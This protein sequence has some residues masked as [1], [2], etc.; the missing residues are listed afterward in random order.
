MFAA[1]DPG[2]DL[3]IERSASWAH[4]AGAPNGRSTEPASATAIAADLTNSRSRIGK[5]VIS[6]ARARI[7]QTEFCNSN[8]AN[9]ALQF[10]LWQAGDNDKTARSWE[11]GQSCA[12]C[13][14][15][16]L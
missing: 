8:C 6:P 3:L 5:P 12:F 10:A 9:R 11:K 15:V 16:L 4:A 7:L 13:Y 1:A 2:A 14:P